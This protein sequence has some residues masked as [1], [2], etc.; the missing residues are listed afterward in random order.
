M[1]FLGQSDDAVNPGYWEKW[2]AKLAAWCD[3]DAQPYLF[4]HTPDNS[5]APQQALAVQNAVAAMTETVPP[6]EVPDFDR[7]LFTIE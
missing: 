6:V 2:V 5:S 3:D 1:R 7:T 4:F